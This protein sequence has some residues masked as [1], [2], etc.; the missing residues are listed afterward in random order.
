MTDFPPPPGWSPPPPPPPGAFP[1]PPPPGSFGPPPG[2][3]ATYGTTAPQTMRYAS[4]WSRLG[5]ALIDGVIVAVFWVPAIVAIV[6]GPTRWEACW[7]DE[8]GERTTGGSVRGSCEV[9]TAGTWAMFAALALAAL[10]ATVLYHALLI[11]RRGQTLG[12]KAL[13]V[14]VVDATNGT[15]IGTGR[16]LGRYLFATFISGN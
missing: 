13:G 12:K 7:L 15:A 2:Y 3:D 1:P 14:R 8:H 9:P 10:V 16:A 11:G 6:A 4:V 5:A